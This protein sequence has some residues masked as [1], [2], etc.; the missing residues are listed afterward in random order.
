[1]KCD[2]R[3]SL[4]GYRRAAP[5]LPPEGCTIE[6]CLE[7]CVDIPLALRVRRRVLISSSGIVPSQRYSTIGF[8]Q[9]ALGLGDP[10]IAA[11]SPSGPGLGAIGPAEAPGSTSD[12]GARLF[13]LGGTPGAGIEL[14]L[15]RED[16]GKRTEMSSSSRIEGLNK[17]CVITLGG[18]GSQLDPS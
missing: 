4:H 17:S 9:S 11:T 13:C 5:Y 7:C 8:R 2:A 12:M 6:G 15:P 1:M 3:E 18:G 16:S 14:P 10:T